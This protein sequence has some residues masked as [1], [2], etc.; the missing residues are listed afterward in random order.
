MPALSWDLEGEAEQLC[1]RKRIILASLKA[2]L[3]ELFINRLQ[4]KN[5][6]AHRITIRER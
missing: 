3:T 6:T 5:N 1:E 4:S 2:I